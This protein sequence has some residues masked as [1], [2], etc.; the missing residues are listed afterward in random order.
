MDSAAALTENS[1]IYSGGPGS[2]PPGLGGNQVHTGS[3]DAGFGLDRSSTNQMETANNWTPGTQ[4][5]GKAN[6]PNQHYANKSDT[7]LGGPGRVNGNP[8]LNRI[9]ISNAEAK[10][11]RKNSDKVCQ[12][13]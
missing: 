11:K 8:G 1:A 3:Q 6:Q 5:N 10:K 4:A 12:V 2:G 7:N 9:N 13:D